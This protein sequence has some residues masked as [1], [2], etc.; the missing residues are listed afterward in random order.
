MPNRFAG[1]RMDVSHLKS[2][3]QSR[4]KDIVARQRADNSRKLAALASLGITAAGGVA[5]GVAG[6]A[7]P[8]VG[9]LAGAGAGMNMGS[10]LGNAF[11]G[12]ILDEADRQEDSVLERELKKRGL[13]EAMARFR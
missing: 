13:Q 9:P 8:G 5:G 12:S 3:P 1:Q 11:G 10:S 7:I 2:T 6:A 4:A